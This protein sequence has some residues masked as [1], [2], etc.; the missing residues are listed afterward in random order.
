MHW[1]ARTEAE[2][3]EFVGLFKQVVTSSYI[4]TIEPYAG[5]K[6]QFVGES[7]SDGTTTVLTRILRRQ[8]DAIP[9]DY[10]MH[11][12]ATQWCTVVDIDRAHGRLV[13]DEV[14]ASREGGTF[15]RRDRDRR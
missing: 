10:R 14:G 7:D 2:R 11:A 8:G 13:P 15:D 12:R 9:V 5:E 4:R 6:V 3:E 1:R